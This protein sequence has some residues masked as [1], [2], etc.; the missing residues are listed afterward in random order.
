MAI[1]FGARLKEVRLEKG[2]TQEALAHKAGLHP[3]YISNCER[4]YSAPT[5]ET[6]IRLARCLGVQP[7]D[8]VDG[9]HIG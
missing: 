8:L 3:T 4:G 6:L 7:G 2:L 5:L 1:A 9:L